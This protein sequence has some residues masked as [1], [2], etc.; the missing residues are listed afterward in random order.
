MKESLQFEAA[1]VVVRLPDW[2]SARTPPRP[3]VHV[4]LGT[5]PASMLSMDQMLD[6]HVGLAIDGEPLTDAE[7]RRL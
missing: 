5:K 6:F 7:R 1:G 4:S 2:W 3:Q